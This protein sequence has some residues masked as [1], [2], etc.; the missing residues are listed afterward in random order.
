MAIGQCLQ[1]A[2]EH[3]R[4]G[5]FSCW[6]IRVFKLVSRHQMPSK[7]LKRIRNLLAR[8]RRWFVLETLIHG[9]I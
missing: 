5:T 8:S 9:K 2:S 1:Q 3:R 4:R 6:K 7:Q